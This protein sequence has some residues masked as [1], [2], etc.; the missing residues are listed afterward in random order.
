MKH[1]VCTRYSAAVYSFS[2]A[3]QI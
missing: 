1:W 3:K 2:Q